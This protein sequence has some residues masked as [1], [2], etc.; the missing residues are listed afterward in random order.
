MPAARLEGERPW[1]PP[2]DTNGLGEGFFFLGAGNS[3]LEVLVVPAQGLPRRDQVRD[4]WRSRQGRQASPLLLIVPFAQ[5]GS[6]DAHLCGPTDADLTVRELAYEQAV[7]LAAGALAELSGQAAVRFLHEK[8]PKEG[9]DFQG[10]INQGMFA[11]HTLRRRVRDMPEWPAATQQGQ[12]IRTTEGRDLV[13][14]L[15]YT[16]ENTNTAIHVLRAPNDQARAVAVFLDR[17]EGPETEGGRFGDTSALSRRSPALSATTS[18]SSSSPA[19]RRSG[20]TP[21]PATKA[22]AARD[23]PKPTCRP[24]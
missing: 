5:N 15:G 23:R 4:V 13:G 3:P 12:Q 9:Q 20:S 8:T 14:A 21:S 6:T 17:D 10:L 2:A 18:R 24:T 16:I 19:D 1:L 22:S 11:A 7:G